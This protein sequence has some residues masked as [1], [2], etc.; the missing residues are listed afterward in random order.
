[1]CLRH[2]RASRACPAHPSQTVAG[3]QRAPRRCRRWSSARLLA[4]NGPSDP[5]DAL[6]M[7]APPGPWYGDQM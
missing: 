4:V 7:S 5:S 1:M 2:A 6:M 3:A